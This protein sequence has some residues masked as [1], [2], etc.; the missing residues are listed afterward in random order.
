LRKF[1][2]ELIEAVSLL[3]VLAAPGAA[4]LPLQS[5]TARPDDLSLVS[6]LLTLVAAISCFVPAR[7]AT[8]VNPMVALRTA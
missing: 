1:A 2:T 4:K 3:G 7:R 8:C 5:E 6:G